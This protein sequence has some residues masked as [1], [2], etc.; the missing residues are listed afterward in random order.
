MSEQPEKILI[1]FHGCLTDGRMHIDATGAVMFESCHVR[2]TRAIRQLI[3]MGFEVVIVTASSNPII[4]FYCK[5][6]GC[7]KLTLRDKS[8]VPFSNFIAL[9]DDAWDMAML[10]QAERAY[11]PADADPQVQALPKI[12]ILKTAGGHGVVAEML[13]AELKIANPLLKLVLDN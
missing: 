5:K 4:D 3:A 9:G 8:K 13:G 11:C 6:L 1:D 10:T 12:R 2:D 7:E